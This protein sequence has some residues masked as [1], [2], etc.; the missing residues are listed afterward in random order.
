M[1]YPRTLR[2]VN[3]SFFLFAP[4]GTGKTTWLRSALKAA[5]YIDLLKSDLCLK[6]NATPSLLRDQLRTLKKKSWVVIDEVQKI[7]ALL[8][9]VH[10]AYENLGLNFAL[11]GSSA[12]KLK[13][14]GANML[15]GRAINLFLFPLTSIELG[16]D[17]SIQK[18]VEWGSLPLMI[19]AEKNL[20]PDI[21]SSYV[22]NY[23]RQELIE[24]GIIRKLEPFIRFLTVAGRLNGQTLNLENISRDAHV[25]RPTVEHYFNI[26]EETMIAKRLP[27]YS[28]N[29]KIKEVAHP[30]VYF[31][32]AG[33]ARA[34]AGMGFEPLESDAK[35]FAFENV[36]YNE[37]KAFNFY[38]KKNKQIFYY[39]T[40]G[41][42]DIDFIL[43]TKVK[44]V[45]KPAEVVCIEVKH[46]KKWDKRWCKMSEDFERVGKTK[47][48]GRYGVYLGEESMEVDGMKILPVMKFLRMLHLGEIY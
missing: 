47:V 39:A 32:D 13:R 9:E 36:I 29:H 1:N 8:D 10:W 28:P 3:Q 48:A 27:A 5:L 30:K 18:C 15:G 25:K 20:I 23:L 12:R 19:H 46:S 4:R 44:T 38:S 45:S 33:V 14:S 24:E 6:F 21:L 40:H 22:E 42:G 26:L 34:C 43:E 41:G 2:T 35:G 16:K 11:T 37:I 7:P 17:F 31:F